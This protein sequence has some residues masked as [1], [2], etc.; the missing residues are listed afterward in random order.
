M[1]VTY[2]P[3]VALPS[4]QARRSPL[5]IPSI[6]DPQPSE[7]ASRPKA[8]KCKIPLAAGEAIC[9][10]RHDDTPGF[11][12]RFDVPGTTGCAAR[13]FSGYH[14]SPAEAWVTCCK[15]VRSRLL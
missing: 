10:S 5:L 4:P 3:F 7:G 14:L 11:A 9:T 2:S 6:F 12:P 1:A 8:K 13:C 15:T